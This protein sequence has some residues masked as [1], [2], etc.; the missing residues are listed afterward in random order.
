MD[1]TGRGSS[2]AEIDRERVAQLVVDVGPGHPRRRASGYRVTASSVLTVGH[3][4]TDA[5]A[6]TVIFNADLPNQQTVRA[7]VALVEP[8]PADVAILAIA[9]RPGQ[10]VAPVSFGRITREA[11]VVRC[12][13][14]GFP[15]WKRRV[16]R[17]SAAIGGS[18]APYRD[19]HQAEGTIAGL[20]NWRQGTMEILVQ[21]PERD[22]DPSRSPWESMSGAAVWSA[23]HIVGLVSEHH[24]SDGLNR[25]TGVRV[26][27]WYE[28]LAPAQLD[29]LCDLTGLPSRAEELV[30]VHPSAAVGASNSSARD[31]TTADRRPLPLPAVRVI[32]E[33]MLSVEELANPMALQQFISLLPLGILGSLPYAPQPRLE[34]VN[35]V[36]G[37]HRAVGGREALVDALTLT[38]GNPAELS[39]ILGVINS[40]WP[41]A[42]VPEGT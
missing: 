13:A 3:A 15:R 9:T 11:N 2:L 31:P 5:Q 12:T 16:G 7:A 40:E 19:S 37:C 25:L 36:R 26:E 42:R 29:R 10:H 28:Q 35:V 27:R 23:G 34:L 14:I 24:A 1:A 8:P 4:V 18:I 21:P 39:R 30:V 17:G 22:A 33:Q 32:V 20:S 6:V 38:V 41:T